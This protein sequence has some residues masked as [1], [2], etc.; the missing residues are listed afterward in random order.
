[1]DGGSLT[2]H[3]LGAGNHVLATWLFLRL[4][5]MIYLVAFISLA[6]QLKGLVGN[7]GIL[8]AAEFLQG[9]RPA[10]GKRFWRLPTL[11]W[12]SASDGFLLLLGWGGAAL[13]LLQ[14][15]GFA[16]VPML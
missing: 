8:P 10:G 1:M 9:R 15:I 13:A 6:V 3:S 4:L 7:Q 16:P 14:T 12:L 2:N 11:C 5:G